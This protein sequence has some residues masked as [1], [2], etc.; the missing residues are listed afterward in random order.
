[1]L[2]IRD[3]GFLPEEEIH[4]RSSSGMPYDYGHSPSYSLERIMEVAE[5]ASSL[6]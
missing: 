5:A 4:T 6:D 1:M 3:L 2:R